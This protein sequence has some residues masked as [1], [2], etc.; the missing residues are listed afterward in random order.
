[1]CSSIVRLNISI[2]PEAE[3]PLLVQ[4]I[5]PITKNKHFK[6]DPNAV[7]APNS[8]VQVFS[9]ATMAKYGESLRMNQNG[10]GSESRRI[11]KQTELDCNDPEIPSLACTTSTSA[12]THAENHSKIPQLLSTVGDVNGH[13]NSGSHGSTNCSIVHQCL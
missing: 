5:D 4:C 8:N 6:V 13:G 3:E 12:A 9:A 1:M 7:Y 10:I 11:N 2:T